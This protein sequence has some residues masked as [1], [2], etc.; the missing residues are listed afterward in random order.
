MEQEQFNISKVLN[1]AFLNN[2]AYNKSKCPNRLQTSLTETSIVNAV[3]YFM[4]L[5][6]WL[7][8]Y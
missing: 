8:K 7:Y 1:N 3:V 4:I 5:H 2:H 6:T